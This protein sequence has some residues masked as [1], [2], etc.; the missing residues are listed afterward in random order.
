MTQ[1]SNQFKK[2]AC[3]KHVM[4]VTHQKALKFIFSKPK[5][6]SLEVFTSKPLVASS[7]LSQNSNCVDIK[8]YNDYRNLFMNIYWCCK[9]ELPILKIPSLHN[10]TKECLNVEIP[11]YHTSIKSCNLF[12][13]VIANNIMKEILDDLFQTKNIGLLLDESTDVSGIPVLL[14]YVR[15]FS[16]RQKKIVEV[17]LKSFELQKTDADTIFSEVVNFL[18]DN[19]LEKK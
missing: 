4:S 10:F 7:F 3:D 12:L 8:K 16:K 6:P 13:E 9:E 15:Y 18:A 5:N 17:F 11:N 14:L 1:G 2:D 19:N